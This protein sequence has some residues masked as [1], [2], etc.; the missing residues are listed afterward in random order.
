MTPADEGHR[1]L[2]EGCVAACPACAHRTLQAKASHARKTAWLHEKLAPWTGV[3]APLEAVPAPQRWNYRRNVCLRTAWQ[4]DAWHFGLM[5]GPRLIPIPDCPVHAPDVRAAVRLLAGVLPPGPDFP[6]AY[7]VQSRAQATLV[8]KTA[9]MPVRTGVDD[10]CWESLMAAGLEGLWLH[11][12]PAAGRRV[13]A[14]KTWH[15]HRGRSRSL[16]ED[17]L[18]YGP[19]AF[20]QLLPALHRRALDEA[21]AF[22]SPGPADAVVD[23]YCGIGASLVRWRARGAA[24]CGVEAGGEAVACAVENAPGATVWRGAC[25]QRLPQLR[26]WLAER[27]GRRLLY[28]NPPRTGLEPDVLA[29][30]AREARPHRLAYLSC[31]A[32]TLRR[33]LDALTDEGYHVERITPYDF[34]PQTYH[35]ET[36][37]LLDRGGG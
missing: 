32:G 2:P 34:F 12:H 27:P 24:V 20:Q 31:S 6:M 8:L 5:R 22:L 28:A 10:A 25:A 29:W 26:A 13:F 23:L 11:L 30:I 21:G 19:T 33:D 18:R 36:L 16:D 35:V 9:T 4:D 1:P 7:Y 37:C 17:G 14:K 3:M 15:L